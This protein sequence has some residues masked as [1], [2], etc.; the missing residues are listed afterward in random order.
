[1]KQALNIL[2]VCPSEEWSTIE[3][4][5]LRDAKVLKDEGHHVFLYCLQESYLDVRAKRLDIKLFYHSG[6]LSTSVLQW[7]KLQLI[8]KIMDQHEIHLVQCYD[9]HLLWPVSFFLRKHQLIPLVFSHNVEF[10]KIYKHWWYQ[11]LIRRIDTTLLP[12]REMQESVVG[13]LGIPPHKI[14]YCGL[15][16]AAERFNGDGQ[17]NTTAQSGHFLENFKEDW[18]IGCYVGSHEQSLDFLLPLF[19]ALRVLVEGRPEGRG[20]KLVLVSD[21]PWEQHLLGDELGHFLVDMGL[22]QNVLFESKIPV[23]KLQRWL[24]LWVGVRSFEAIDD[25]M[26]TALLAG[27]P[28]VVTRGTATMELLRR[29]PRLGSTYKRGDARELRRKIEVILGAYDSYRDAIAATSEELLNEFGLET[30]RE[31][32]LSVYEKSLLKRSRFYRRIRV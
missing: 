4:T 13:S 19:H 10:Q 8:P 30:Y 18:K 3:R 26:V 32:L 27:L 6:K 9:I 5:A 17:A 23:T 21:K 25:Y 12:S 22:D 20:V 24:D 7:R 11:P 29:Q 15:G 31:Q 14:D 16:V 1:M 28:V 2:L